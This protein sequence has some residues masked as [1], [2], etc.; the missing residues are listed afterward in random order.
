MYLKDFDNELFNRLVGNKKVLSYF[1]KL[2]FSNSSETNNLQSIY[3]GAKSRWTSLDTPL[4]VIV[5]EIESTIIGY[6]DSQVE[7][8]ATDIDVTKYRSVPAAIQGEILT[9]VD[10]A[11]FRV[12]LVNLLNGKLIK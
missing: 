9:D 6:S 11:D 8:G 4:E 7:K 2:L 10:D 1:T 12:F 3:D 5:K